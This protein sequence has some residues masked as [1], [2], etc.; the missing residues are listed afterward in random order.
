MQGL[1]ERV[2]VVEVG[3]R[4]GLQN[5]PG[6]VPTEIK[7]AYVRRLARA[8]LL[9]IEVTSFVHPRRIPQLADAEQLLG[10]LG[11][12]AG[13]GD[14]RLSAL[15]PNEQGLERALRT[16]IPRIAVFTAASESFT[17]QNIGMTVEESLAAFRPVVAGARA[18]GLTVRGYVS[19]CWVCPYEGEVPVE[20]VLRVA[21]ALLEM[22]A[23]EVSLG[24]TVGAA[25]P[26]E[27]AERLSMLEAQLPKERLALHFHDTSGTALA[28]VFAALQMGFA[29]FDSSAGGLGG[30]PYAP[31]AAGNLATEDLLYMLH[32]M[33]IETGVSLEGVVEASAFLEPHLGH[34]LPSRQYRR[35]VSGKASAESAP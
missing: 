28:N 27:V 10:D 18:A 29:T 8:G 24:D 31:G 4:D 14:A 35:L 22:G 33:G 15:V 6:I 34:A 19:T 32:R 17:R 13:D 16:G 30:C 5:E 3:P 9:E 2:K 20:P 25:V 1:P 12:A 26:T 7:A 23:D 21:E 11:A